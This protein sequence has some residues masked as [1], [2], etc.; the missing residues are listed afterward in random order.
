VL[1]ALD[2]ATDFG[3]ML[4]DAG[5][6]LWSRTGDLAAYRRN[7]LALADDPGRRRAMGARGRAH[8]ERH[9]T[10]ER[11]CDVLERR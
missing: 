1:A 9:F 7:L 8:L 10:V 11:A 4:D 3:A 6:G 2:P 5:A